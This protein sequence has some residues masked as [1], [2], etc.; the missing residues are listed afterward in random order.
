MKAPDKPMRIVYDLEGRPYCVP[1]KAVSRKV[2]RAKAKHHRHHD[3]G[4]L[5]PPP[6]PLWMG[7]ETSAPLP[8]SEP[9]I[10]QATRKVPQVRHRVRHAG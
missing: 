1:E 5:P 4:M 7:H 2:R 9:H 3:W 10:I 6:A 8:H